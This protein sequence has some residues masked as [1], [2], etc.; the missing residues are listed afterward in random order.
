MD[1]D[2]EQALLPNGNENDDDDDDDSDEQ[3]EPPSKR[4]IALKAT[5]LLVLGTALIGLF[6]DPLVSFPNLFCLVTCFET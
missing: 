4:A 6:S 3:K 2:L 1:L 5:T